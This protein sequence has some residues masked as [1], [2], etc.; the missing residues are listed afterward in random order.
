MRF[1]LRCSKLEQNAV[2]VFTASPPLA[3]AETTQLSGCDFSPAR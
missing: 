2:S 3:S 1:N